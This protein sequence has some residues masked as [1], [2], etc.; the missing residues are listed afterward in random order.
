[1]ND[2]GMASPHGN[3]R[4][5]SCVESD[6]WADIRALVDYSHTDLPY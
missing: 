3:L 6:M 1:L 4:D 5:S 2:C